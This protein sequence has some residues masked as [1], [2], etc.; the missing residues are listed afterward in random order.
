MTQ[1]IE[2]VEIISKSNLWD[3]EEDSIQELKEL[4]EDYVEIDNSIGR[5]L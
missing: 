5:E 2:A 3:K 1:F 4:A